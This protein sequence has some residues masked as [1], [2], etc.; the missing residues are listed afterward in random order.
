MNLITTHLI[1]II[2]K[3]NINFLDLLKLDL[4]IKQI[5]FKKDIRWYKWLKTKEMDKYKEKHIPILKNQQKYHKKKLLMKIHYQGQDSII[6]MMKYLKNREEILFFKTQK[7]F[8]ACML[9]LNK[10]TI[11]YK[12]GKLVIL[13]K[14]LQK[15]ESFKNKDLNLCKRY[16]IQWIVL[17]YVEFC[18]NKIRKRIITHLNK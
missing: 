9:N 5:A 12:M 7:D 3:K 8:K 6:Q 10:Y 17:K 2:K 18:V 1:Q 13:I 14:N 11:Q 16:I 4:K 15:M